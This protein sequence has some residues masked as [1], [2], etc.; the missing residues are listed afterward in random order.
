MLTGVS[1]LT[2]RQ[3]ARNLAARRG[4][5]LEQAAAGEAVTIQ[6]REQGFEPF[7]VFVEDGEIGHAGGSGDPTAGS[8]TLETS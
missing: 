2:L 6:G 1:V 3:A 8:Y 7:G 5:D 4:H